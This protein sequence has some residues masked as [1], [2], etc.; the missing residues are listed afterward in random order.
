[1]QIV[2]DGILSMKGD[3]QKELRHTFTT[4]AKECGISDEIVKIWTARSLQYLPA[5]VDTQN[6]CKSRQSGLFLKFRSRKS[7]KTKNKTQYI[8]KHFSI[9]TTIYCVL[10]RA[11]GDSNLWPLESENYDRVV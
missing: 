4:Q 6:L 2:Y 1:M 8:A 11:V 5:R 7:P 9:K 3:T 10:W